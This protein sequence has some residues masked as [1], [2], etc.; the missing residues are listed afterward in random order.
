MKLYIKA[1]LGAFLMAA[2]SHIYAHDFWLQPERFHTKQAPASV[3]LN[4]Q[5]GHNNDATPWAL[6]WQRIVALRSYGNGHYQDQMPNI[7]VNNGITN[8][9]A[10]VSLDEEGTHV[11]GFESYHSFSSLEAQRFNNYAKKEGLA[12]VLEERMRTGNTNNAGTELYSR[13]AKSIIQVGNTPSMNVTQPIGLTLEIVPMENPYA[14]SDESEL[15]LRVLFK[16]RPLENALIDIAPMQGSDMAKQ[17]IRT[18][19][20]GE[21]YFTVETKGSWIANVIW[22]VPLEN[23]EKADFESYFSS[24]TFGYE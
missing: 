8:G 4:F 2:S 5:I 7:M 19:N 3:K 12:L 20:K 16:G 22:A 10:K 18:N 13:K 24:L 17:S 9:F 6:E 11:L 23:N 1:V 15:P 21:A 14:L